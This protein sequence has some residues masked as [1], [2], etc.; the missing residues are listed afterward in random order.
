MPAPVAAVI[1]MS[2]I[3]K[4]SLVAAYA[5]NFG[6]AYA[7]GRVCWL[8]LA[9]AGPHDV[10]AR[11]EE[12]VRSVAELMGLP[13][14]GPFRQGL[15]GLVAD[16]LDRLEGPSLW[17]VEDVPTGLDPDTVRQLVLP[18]GP[19]LRTVFLTHADDYRDVATTVRLDPME[20]EDTGRLLAGFRE[21]V[22]SERADFERLVPRLGGHPIAV[23]LVGN[24][25]RDREGLLSFG[26]CADRL[27]ADPDALAVVTDLLA[28]QVHRLSAAARLVLQLALLG[29][30]ASLPARYV[31]AV[32]RR[33]LPDA[34][35]DP[36]G[37][38]L[39]ELKDVALAGRYG[40]SWQVHALVLDA[41]RRH[42]D[43]P[44]A[45]GELAG[46]AAEVL[47]ALAA[48]PAL[49]P[50][51]RADVMRHTAA[52]ATDLPVGEATRLLL[53]VATYYEDRGAAV[54]AAPLRDRLVELDPSSAAAF[55]A[56]AAAHVAAGD[57]E[58]AAEHAAR[59]MGMSDADAAVAVRLRRT[60]A[61]ALDAQGRY[62]E[63][64]PYWRAIL[65]A[66]P[67]GVPVEALH[68]RVAHLRN[69]RLR[70]EMTEVKAT[71]P[72][73]HYRGDGPGP[74]R[75]AGGVRPRA[76]GGTG[77]RPRRAAH[78]RAAGRSDHGRGRS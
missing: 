17:V 1:G 30:P 20:D 35:P 45:P 33:L 48:D 27:A 58:R 41:A 28:D 69:R 13:V 12:Q 31:G 65:G 74:G 38:A 43:R 56:A 59:G 4:T 46:T 53:R 62:T 16:H 6:A 40:T 50:S 34:G 5:W 10:L 42:L 36:A 57:Y 73:P 67:G 52:L 14:R 19:L 39:V 64:E 8:D 11:Y 18:G 76:G 75:V 26:D 47:D 37:D 54:L 29:A 51:D 55:A 15:L 3:G 61:E 21:P 44:V 60:L 70:G 32:V 24:Q 2:G 71:A 63:S 68:S 9:G 23:R 78:R 77:A 66:D 7:G 72:G 49:D 25:L 22:D